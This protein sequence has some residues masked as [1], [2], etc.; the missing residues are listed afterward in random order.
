MMNTKLLGLCAA[1]GIAMSV[2]AASAETLTFTGTGDV[3]DSSNCFQLSGSTPTYVPCTFSAF[4]GPIAI[5]GTLD[6]EGGNLVSGTVDGPTVPTTGLYNSSFSG[7]GLSITSHD[8]FQEYSLNIIFYLATKSL[9]FTYGLEQY[10]YP[11]Y[12]I[13]NSN[14]G[15][16]SITVTPLPG[17]LP[18]FG[19]VLGAA[20]LLGWRRKRKTRAAI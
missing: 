14:D 20:S 15:T 16:G 11:N 18:L 8:D 7:A 3:V 13:L 19:T 17:A 2:G 9:T 6:V 5:S 4:D 12:L 1:I 10:L